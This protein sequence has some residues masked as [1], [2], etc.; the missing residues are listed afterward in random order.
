[1]DSTTGST[2]EY[3]TDDYHPPSDCEEDAGSSSNA[4]NNGASTSNSGNKGG[5]RVTNRR[6]TTSKSKQ[7][8]D[9][10]QGDESDE[11][12]DEIELSSTNNIDNS[13]SQKYATGTSVS[14]LF[15]GSWFSGLITQ[16]HVKEK[17]YTVQYDDGDE[18]DYSEKEVGDLITNHHRTTT[19]SSSNKTNAVATGKSKS[20]EQS[21]DGSGSDDD[22]DNFFSHVGVN[23]TKKR[24]VIQYS[25]DSDDSSL[26]DLTSKKQQAKKLSTGLSSD[27]ESDNSDNNFFSKK[28]VVAKKQVAEVHQS[29]SSDSD[30]EIVVQ[31]TTTNQT[32]TSTRTSPRRT[33]QQQQRAPTPSIDIKAVPSPKKKKSPAKQSSQHTA[34]RARAESALEYAKRAREE[35]KRA[36]NYH[37]EDVEV[38]L[39]TPRKKAAVESIDVDDSSVEEVEALKPA[40]TAVPKPKEV[41]YKGDLLRITL[42]YKDST[43][44]KDCQAVLR[45]RSDEPLRMLKERFQGGGSIAS[46]KFDGDKLDMNKTP[47]FYDMED[48]DLVDAV[49]QGGTAGG[50]GGKAPPDVVK[51][52]VRRSGTTA[53]HEFGMPKTACLSKLIAAVCEKFKVPHVVL[54]YNGRSLN[55]LRSCYDEGISNNATIDAIVGETINLEFRVNGDSKDVHSINAMQRGTFRHAMEV[56]AAKKKCSVADCKFLFDGEV[57]KATTTMESLELEGD[58]IIDVQLT[59]AALNPLSMQDVDGDVIMADAAAV[60]AAV[61]SVKTVRNQ[62]KAKPKTWKISTA[63][64][65]SKLKLDYT[66]HYKTCKQVK[67]YF[68]NSCINVETK[69]LMELGITDGTVLYAMEN[70]KPYKIQ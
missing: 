46:L 13:S 49:V 42:R 36:Q 48:E 64:K 24:K 70:G 3:E 43:N 7:D 26:E 35:M 58:E 11:S 10:Y 38:K 52:L 6:S 16:Y 4:S 39:P 2:D 56:F 50:G 68:N 20:S 45:I 9:S 34:I 8:D 59:V 27:E 55:P 37:A 32:S 60:R 1:M 14:K 47:Q 5:K 19:T 66:K 61:I 65:I 15:N 21:N 33:T 25:D 22:D 23:S 41:V 44:Q 51:L 18:E 30:I 57:L 31:S 63:D 28:R 53:S 17:L 12:S 62:T 29:D 69:S 54:E 67:F 40:A